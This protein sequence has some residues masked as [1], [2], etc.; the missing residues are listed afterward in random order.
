GRRGSGGRGPP[1]WPGRCPGRRHWLWRWPR[2]GRS[3]RTGSH[4]RARSAPCPRAHRSSRWRRSCRRGTGR[5]PRSAAS[6]SSAAPMRP[7][8][9]SGPRARSGGS[10]PVLPAVVL[11]GGLRQLVQG[12][13][14]VNVGHQ[15]VVA[16]GG[17]V[18]AQLSVV[19]VDVPAVVLHTSSS[20]VSALL[21][22]GQH[23]LEPIDQRFG[24]LREVLD[25]GGVY[26]PLP[27]AQGLPAH[28]GLR[29][30]ERRVG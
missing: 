17:V 6:T 16:G 20:S 8:T 25:G 3:A 29:S 14:G 28:T 26:A 7:R 12:L 30:E 18:V 24:Q 4:R 10:P 22:A 1:T 9:P 15:V 27:G 5:S 19:S 23:P 13:T 2:R 21:D 11:L